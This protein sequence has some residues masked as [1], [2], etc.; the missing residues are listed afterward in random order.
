MTSIDHRPTVASHPVHRATILLAE[1]STTP[2]V[3]HTGA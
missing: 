3:H 2:A 1:L